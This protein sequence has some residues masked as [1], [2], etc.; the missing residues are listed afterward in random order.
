MNEKLKEFL[1]A[2][3]EAEQKKY[4]EEKQ[5]TL[6][7][8]GLFEKVYSPDNNYSE[9]FSSCEWDSAN[10][11][12]KYYKKVTVEIT[13]EE[14]QEVKKY[15]KKEETTEN[16]PIATALTVIAWIVFIGGFIAGI[17]LGTVE[18]ERGYY[19][20]YTDTEFSFA[21][22]FGYWCVSLISGTMFLG[23][24]EIIKLLNDIKRK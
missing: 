24:A 23:F 14:Y 16:N 3:K 5:K 10:S 7:E 17:A 15:S 1:D 6:I 8:L 22:A 21:I 18:V 19:Y 2:K 20:T 13:D 11:T 4:E 9:E 12:N